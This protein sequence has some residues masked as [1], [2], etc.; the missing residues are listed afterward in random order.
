MRYVILR[1]RASMAMLYWIASAA[2]CS[3]CLGRRPSRARMTRCGSSCAAPVRC[4]RARPAALET[5]RGLAAS[6][7]PR[8]ALARV[9]QLQPRDPAAPRWAEWEALRIGLLVAARAPRR[10]A[11]SGRTRCR[12]TC[13]APLLRE[14]PARRR[15]RRRRGRPGRRRAPP[16]RAR[17]VAARALG[18]GNAR[19]AARSSST[20]TSPSG[21]ATRRFGAMLRFQQDYAPLDARHRRAL[22][23]GAARARDGEAGGQLAREP[24]RCEPGEA[25]AAV[26]DRARGAGERAIAQARAALAKGGGAGYWRVLAEVAQRQQGRALRVEALEQLLEFRRGNS[27]GQACRP[28]GGAVGVL[29]RR[30]A[31][32]R[33]PQPDADR[34]R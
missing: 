20:A 24:R 15:A 21:R 26:E 2:C 32:R 30:S 12:R 10:G 7:A 29:P 25:R 23:R 19:R 8:L 11:C 3:E 33:Q 31:G 18:A 27:G 9:E 13:R 17:A 1:R 16:C 34:R 28:R 22:R 14:S 5:A 6:G 4:A